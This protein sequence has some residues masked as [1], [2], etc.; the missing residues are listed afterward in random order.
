MYR[1]KRSGGIGMCRASA[2]YIQGGS[3]I[4]GTLSKLHCRTE[5]H[6]FLLILLLQ[7]VSAVCRSINKNNNTHSSKVE[8]TGSYKSRDNRWTSRRTYI[9]GNINYI[10][11]NLTEVCGEEVWPPSTPD[12]KP[13][14]YFVWGVSELRV[15]A[16]CHNKFKALI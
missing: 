14:D 8:A 15:N 4:S 10:K 2:R 16:K 1:K 6:F 7:T 12:C 11:E 9:D 3:D 13:F 5:K